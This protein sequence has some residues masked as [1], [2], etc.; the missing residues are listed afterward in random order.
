M[1]HKI[2]GFQRFPQLDFEHPAL[3]RL[4]VHLNFE[5]PTWLPK[6]STGKIDYAS[7]QARLRA[8]GPQVDVNVPDAFRQAF[9]PRQV[10]PGDT[11][12]KLG[13]D[14]LL[15]VQL[16]LTLEREL[17]NLPEGWETMSL[18]DLAKIAEPRNHYRSIDSQLVLR[19]A[20]I[21]LVVIHHATLWP[22]PGEPPCW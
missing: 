22:I 15:Y 5:E 11:F 1:E 13:G 12:E 6:L 7:L 19:A 10:G 14:S 16:A 2:A 4:R 9:Y 21:L 18:G 8:P 17:G 3:P 20:A